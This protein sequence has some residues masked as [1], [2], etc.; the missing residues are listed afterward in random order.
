MIGRD[1]PDTDQWAD[2]HGVVHG[3]GAELLDDVYEFLGRF[4]AYPSEHAHVA[5]VLWIAHAWLMDCWDSTPRI[6]FLS[7]EPGS[8]KSRCVE[9][10]G[11]LVPRPVHAV[12]VTSAYLFR[13]IGDEDGRPTIL[14]DEVDTVF[15]TRTSGENEDVRGL[16]NA[17]HRKGAVVGRCMMIGKTVFTEELPVYCAV[18]L[19]G[20]NDLPDTLMTRSVIVRMRRRS[21]D[22]VVES[23][24]PRLCEPDAEKL[25]DRLLSWSATAQ[26]F[27]KWPA[28]PEGVE[29]RNADC[30][31]PL[32]AVADVVGGDWPNRARVS[33]VSLVSDLRTASVSLGVTLLRD[34]R[35]IFMDKRADRLTTEDVLT[36]LHEIVESPWSELRGKPLDPRGLARFLGKYDVKS[37]QV[38][39][40][41]RTLKG[42]ELADLIDPFSRYLPPLDKDA[43]TSNPLVEVEVG[44]YRDG[45]EEKRSPGAR[46]GETSET[47]ETHQLHLVAP[48][49]PDCM[50]P[51]DSREH[52]GICE[53]A[54]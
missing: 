21:P 22:E 26:Q 7:P 54:A 25:A 27:V 8:G 18:A 52:D 12:N 44:G 2:E 31:E 49:C 43:N 50:F 15:G 14:Y 37:K 47:S 3:E 38:R 16:L 46:G 34:L 30:W 19:A 23:W 48:P 45:Q 6:A 39:I 40:G 32:L 53:G 36:A 1:H 24:R 29:D 4:I 28:M 17:G 10:T 42:Y 20:L 5:H 35:Q 9:V 41:E 51:I 13:K 33:A 11:P